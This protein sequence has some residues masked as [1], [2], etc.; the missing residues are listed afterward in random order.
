[1]KELTFEAIMMQ[2]PCTTLERIA[3]FL[4]ALEDRD[5]VTLAKYNCG[6]VAEKFFTGKDLKAFIL[7]TTEA[8]RDYLQAVSAG[9]DLD[10]SVDCESYPSVMV[11]AAKV[12]LEIYLKEIEKKVE[13]ENH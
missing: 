13:N 7:S 6:W 12:F 1:M 5:P 4:A 3:G 10:Q 11:V 9:K 2:N 8:L